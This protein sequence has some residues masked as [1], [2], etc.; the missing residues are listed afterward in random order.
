MSTFTNRKNKITLEDYNY[1]RD[2]ENRLFMAELSILEVDVLSE[3]VNGSLKTSFATIIDNLN[4]GT[5]QLKTVLEKLVKS[6]LFVIQGESIIVDKEMRKYYEAQII[7]FDDD[8]KPDMEYLQGLLS[9]VPIHALPVWYTI[10]RSSDNIFQSIVEK[11]LQTPRIYERYLQELIFEDP[12]LP[13]I[14]KTVFQAP[15]FKI[16]SQDL[17]KKFKI[18]KEQF[19]EHMLTLEFS[20]VCCISYSKTKDLWEEIVTPFHEWREYLLFLR[21]TKPA[22]INDVKKIKRQHTD[23]FGFIQELNAL[24]NKFLKNP[25]PISETS[26]ELVD[27]ACLLKVAQVEKKKINATKHTA[28][29]LTKSPADQAI[30]LYRE[31]LNLL[32]LSDEAGTFTE[33]DYREV[34]KSLRRITKG[35]WVLFDDFMKGCLANVGSASTVSLRKKGKHWKY[36]IPHFHDNDRHFIQKIICEYLMQA[37]MVDVGYLDDQLCICLTPFGRVALGE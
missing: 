17:I 28:E 21:D 22:S 4:I 23:D 32:M 35:G 18:S 36:T 34:E 11:F 26:K 13:E 7:K 5:K 31:I 30:F 1:R 3:I 27:V 10:P 25:I 2:I 15:D 33:K 12:I 20:F 24:L 9:K 8:F 14:I 29:W 19:E 6:N 16:T 37:G